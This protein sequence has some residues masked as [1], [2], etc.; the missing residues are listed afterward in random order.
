MKPSTILR[1]G[2]ATLYLSANDSMAATITYVGTETTGAGN[3]FLVPNWS[4]ASVAKNHDLDG[5]NEYGSAGYYQIRPMPWDPG[6][7]SIGAG[8][9]AGND[10]G[11]S[12]GSNPTLVLAPSFLSSISGGAGTYV[13]YGGYPI[14]RGPDGTSLYREGSLSVAVSNGL[15]N[16]PAGANT[17]YFGEAFSFTVGTAVACRIGITVDTAANGTYAPNYVSI[18]SSSTGTVFSGSLTRDGN[19]DM[20]IFDI[21]AGAGEGF[22]AAVWQLSGTQSVA[23]FGLVTFD[24][25]PEPSS[26]LLAFLGVAAVGVWHRRRRTA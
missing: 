26:G 11:V 14:F 17:G 22:V 1:L 3:G 18:F 25:I 23:P 13:N 7:A 2:L 4:N 9:G 24:V 12:A 5:N 10:L 16:T 6:A 20:A 8:A 15:Y 19:P 21:T